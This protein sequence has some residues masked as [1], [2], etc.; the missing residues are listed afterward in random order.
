MKYTLLKKWHP[1]QV[2]EVGHVFEENAQS[3]AGRK[4][5]EDVTAH[6]I[7]L[8]VHAGYLEKQK[9]VKNG[10]DYCCQEIHPERIGGC[11]HAH[12]STCK[13]EKK[14]DPTLDLWTTEPPEGTKY[15]HLQEHISRT[16]V[17]VSSTSWANDIFD[18]FRLKT[19]NCHKTQQ[20]AEEALK[21]LLEK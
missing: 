5:Y 1:A 8:L 16:E 11:H 13:R 6:E 4:Y 14:S 7:A 20:S 19:N 21:R 17:Y 9:E 3:L 15:W 2:E 10:C 12:L 18:K